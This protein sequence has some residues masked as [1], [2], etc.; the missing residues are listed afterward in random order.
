MT[1]IDPGSL[2]SR[3]LDAR[4]GGLPASL[5]VHG[6]RA[7]TQ[8]SALV[9]LPTGMQARD[10]LQ[11]EDLPGLLADRRPLWIRLQGMADPALIR[12]VLG[13]LGVPPAFHAPLLEVPQRPRVDSLGDVVL[14]ILHRL[15]C[16]ET[17]E[18]LV[19]EQVGLLLLPNLLISI[20]EVPKP[21]SFPELTQWLA[22]LDPPPTREDLDDI[23]H[24]L[25]DEV[26]DDLF[27]LLEK[28]ADRLEALEEEA[29]RHPTPRLL[30]RAYDV[31]GSLRDIRG[32]VWPLRHQI[33]VLLRQTQRLLGPE[34]LHGFQDMEQRV[35]LIF[36]GCELLRRQ[37]DSVTDAYMA[38]ISNRMNQVMKTLAIVSSIFAPLTFIAG[39][40]GMNFVAMP[41]LKWA[42][43]YAL[44]LV[45]M[46][47]V[48]LLQSY[49][50]WRRGWF[51]DWT[52]LRR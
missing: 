31:R 6:G 37:C 41:E 15:S 20:E 24:F 52:A 25:I 43:G 14:A 11:L 38:S 45:A 46:A 1:R 40:Y 29:L 12:A 30:N 13:R 5:F 19:G 2:R 8:L 49:W 47:S 39:I 23:L 48:A 36:E 18:R 42:Y 21:R 32:Q 10:A 4:P 7:P 33:M 22:S 9:F 51:Q 35:G 26:L 50:L 44:V 28:L 17:T 16:S 27:P 34:A 3:P